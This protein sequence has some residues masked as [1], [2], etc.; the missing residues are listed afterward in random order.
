ML[1]QVGRWERREDLHHLG[2]AGVDP[3][4]IGLLSS[5]FEHHLLD[6]DGIVVFLRAKDGLARPGEPGRAAAASGG[7]A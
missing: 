4:P 2:D 1:P 3:C 5:R 6:E 7:K